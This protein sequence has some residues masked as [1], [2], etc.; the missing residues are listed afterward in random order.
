MTLGF[1]LRTEQQHATR[2][3]LAALTAQAPDSSAP[4]AMAVNACSRSM[5]VTTSPAAQRGVSPRE[6]LHLTLSARERIK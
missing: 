5:Q 6:P 1:R 3:R 2:A 4:A